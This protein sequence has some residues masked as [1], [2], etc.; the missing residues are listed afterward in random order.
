MQT[1]EIF[2]RYST[3]SPF[4]ALFLKN[5]PVWRIY[6]PKASIAFFTLPCCNSM[7]LALV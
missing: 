7:A 6:F 2:L 5:D 3:R 1:F 4:I